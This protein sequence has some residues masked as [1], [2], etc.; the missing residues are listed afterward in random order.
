MLEP[1][2]FF[3]THLVDCLRPSGIVVGALALASP[4]LANVGRTVPNRPLEVQS[5]LAQPMS[6]RLAC[7]SIAT[8]LGIHGCV[9]L[10]EKVI[11]ICFIGN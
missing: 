1:V 2:C 3:S 8:F 11:N 7:S 9:R 10:F 4:G 5:L 6:N